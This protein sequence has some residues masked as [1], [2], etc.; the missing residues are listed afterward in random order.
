MSN[1]FSKFAKVQ[2]LGKSAVNISRRVKVLEQLY[3]TPTAYLSY[4]IKE[5]ERPEDIAYY[6]YEDITK[7]WLVFL[8][9]NIVDPYSQWPLDQ[10]NFESYIIAKYQAQS[11]T[12][13]YNVLN[14]TRNTGITANVVHYENIE[15]PTIKIS[16]DTFTLNS[17][18]GLI[19]SAE[20]QPVRYYDYELELNENKRNIF[21]VN[22]T[23]AKQ[24]QK[25]LEKLVNA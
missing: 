25:E 4:T 9:N 22:R 2:Y 10:S 8:A 6:Y 3:S 7:V 23:Y 16:K 5:G 20:W 17:S 18:L 14:W 21:L 19:Q 1:Y 24:M 12:T 15:D 11:G 13:G